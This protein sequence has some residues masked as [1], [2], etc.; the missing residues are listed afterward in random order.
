M[1]KVEVSEKRRGPLSTREQPA[2]PKH[3]AG[4]I[5]RRLIRISRLIVGA[6]QHDKSLI[7][8]VVHYTHQRQQE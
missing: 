2:S 5:G 3:E 8:V 4:K 7:I 6:A 1:G